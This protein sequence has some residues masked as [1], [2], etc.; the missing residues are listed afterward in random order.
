M[1]RHD[2]DPSGLRWQPRHALIA[3]ETSSVIHARRRKFLGVGRFRS[4]KRMAVEKQVV[5]DSADLQPEGRPW[6]DH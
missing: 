5:F 6:I 2:R 3:W 1:S 4:V